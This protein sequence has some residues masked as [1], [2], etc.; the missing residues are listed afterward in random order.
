MSIVLRD[1][2]CSRS[3]ILFLLLEMSTYE[4]SVLDS[5]KATQMLKEILQLGKSGSTSN[6]TMGE[7]DW[8]FGGCTQR[9][10]VQ[11]FEKIL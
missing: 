9:L 4:A 10:H 2:L 11:F 3:V 1:C 8:R 7:Y 6:V 5:A